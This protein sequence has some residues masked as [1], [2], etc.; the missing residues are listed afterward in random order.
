MQRCSTV[1]A[2][3]FL[4]AYNRGRLHWLVVEGGLRGTAAMLPQARPL[5]A[6]ARIKFLPPYEHLYPHMTVRKP[7]AEHHLSTVT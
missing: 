5:V 2:K 3:Y 7:A 4:E 6:P 1:A